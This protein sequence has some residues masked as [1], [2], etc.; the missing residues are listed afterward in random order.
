MTVEN[1]IINNLELL[2][3]AYN[4]AVNGN[5]KK[6]FGRRLPI[7]LE[8]ISVVLTVR[9]VSLLEAMMLKKFSNSNVIE[10]DDY[11]S[12]NVPNKKYGGM[13]MYIDEL[14]KL[15][16]V[17]QKDNDVKVK[18]NMM[19]FPI[20]ELKK[21]IVLRFSGI[22]LLNVIGPIDNLPTCIFKTANKDTYE[23][24]IISYFIKE[25]YNFMDNQ[26]QYVD[27][28]SDAALH[29]KYLNSI[30]DKDKIILSQI[31]TCFGTID[32]LDQNTFPNNLAKIN[33]NKFKSDCDNSNYKLYE[34][35]YLDSIFF[36]CSTSLYTFFEIF[37]NSPIGSILEFT[38]FKIVFSDKENYI[39]YDDIE[40]YNRRLV[41]LYKLIYHARTEVQTNET[42][43]DK[44]NYMMLSQKMN[45]TLKIKFSDLDNFIKFLERYIEKEYIKTNC[46]YTYSYTEIKDIIDFI[47]MSASALYNNFKK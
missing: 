20:S 18:P 46:T 29:S 22:S 11:I 44:F 33:S 15:N 3:D 41:N 1:I 28:A 14:S 6:D 32:F 9:D 25:F 47:K 21:T 36:T 5:I 16:D 12:K 38:D 19:I 43:L 7:L 10:Y 4:N 34:L 13:S 45:Y 42:R 24:F 35:D 17:I 30:K 31:N 26:I 37:L 8:H 23:D 40:K 2:E 27:L 39:S